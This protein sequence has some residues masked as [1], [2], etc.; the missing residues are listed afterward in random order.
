MFAA[1]KLRDRSRKK[2]K[3]WVCWLSQNI[4]WSV[5]MKFLAKNDFFNDDSRPNE[6]GFEP[7]TFKAKYFID[8]CTLIQFTRHVS[9][10]WQKRFLSLSN[11]FARP[12]KR[13]KADQVTQES[14]RPRRPNVT[15]AP[16]LETFV[17]VSIASDEMSRQ[18]TLMI[19]CFKS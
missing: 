14:C 18:V 1:G 15:F 10:T 13:L 4:W 9:T 12:K 16:P 11:I 6:L 2:V 5:A 3:G 8:M 17:T 7:F 19:S